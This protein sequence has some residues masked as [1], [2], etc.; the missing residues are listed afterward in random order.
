MLNYM[1]THC[2]ILDVCLV[3]WG[4]RTYFWRA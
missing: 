3:N 1:K 2:G 4:L